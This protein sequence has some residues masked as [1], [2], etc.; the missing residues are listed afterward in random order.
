[1]KEHEMNDL[2]QPVGLPVQ[3]WKIPAH[4]SDEPMVGR[5]CI[6]ESLDPA[7]HGRDLYDA[8]R[9][10]KNGLNWAYLPYGPFDEFEAYLGWMKS[11]C[12]GAD[13]LFFAIVDKGTGKAAGVASFMRIDPRAGSIEIGHLNFSPLL[14]K[15]PAATEAIFMMMGRA[16]E[17]G[18]RRCEWKCNAL[19]AASRSAAQRFGFSFEGIFRQANVVKGRNRDTAWYA[20][21]DHEW[22]ELSK[23]FGQWLAPSNFDE[24]GNQLERLSTFTRP[25]LF[26]I[27]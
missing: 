23:A 22:P 7:R 3:G 15:K 20:A 11:T 4:P 26:R 19:N 1:M 18:Y 25:L 13:P 17:A 16:F 8:N 14:Q 9:L 5:F 21:M 12:T 6:L 24:K 2:G 27:G 10:D